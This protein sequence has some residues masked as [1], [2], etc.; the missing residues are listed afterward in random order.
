MNSGKKLGPSLI[1][2]GSRDIEDSPLLDAQID[3]LMGAIL[4]GD[5]EAP[6][7]VISGGCRGVD[8]A[9]EGWACDRDV[10]VRRFPADWSRGPSGGPRRNAEMV[11]EADAV[12]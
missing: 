12:V 1:I 7:E 4:H 6:H 9:G 2:C 3:H 10:P 11:A 5:S 8:M